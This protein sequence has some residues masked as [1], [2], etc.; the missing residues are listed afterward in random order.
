MT[1]LR[2][3]KPTKGCSANGRKRLTSCKEHNPMDL[4]PSLEADGFSVGQK[5]PCL[6]QN[7]KIQYCVYKSTP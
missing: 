4:S 1:C 7:L 3:P 2:K 6:L 5:I